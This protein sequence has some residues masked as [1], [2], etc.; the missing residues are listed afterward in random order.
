MVG[1][2][3]TLAGRLSS[4]M[5]CDKLESCAIEPDLTASAAHVELLTNQAKRRRVEG[6]VEDDIAVTMQDDQFPARQVVGCLGQRLEPCALD[7]L[8]LDQRRLF[9]RAVRALA[10]RGATPLQHIRIGLG[11]AGGVRPPRK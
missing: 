3:Q 7:L 5:G 6:I 4:W 10:S 1:M 2:G 11:V 9:G 8:E